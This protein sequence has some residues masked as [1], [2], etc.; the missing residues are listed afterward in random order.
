MGND[1]IP[2]GDVGRCTQAG[3]LPGQRCLRANSS[4]TPDGRPEVV[5]AAPGT[6]LPL[7]NPGAAFGGAGAAHLIDGA[8][9]AILYTYVT[10]EPQRGAAFS[11]TFEQTIAAGDLGESGL[12]DV[13][14]G[15][16][17]QNTRYVA[18][19]RGYAMTGNFKAGPVLLNIG[20]IDDPT[21]DVTEENF[22]GSAAGVGDLVP[23]PAFP[24]NELLVGQ[25]G[26]RV[27][28][29]NVQG[30]PID[31]HFFNPSLEMALQSIQD[32]DAVSSS[33]FGDSI[34]PLGDLNEDG[35]LDFA[36]GAQR[37]SNTSV[38]FVGR[39]YIFR[40]DNSPAPAPPWA[41]SRPL[42]PPWA[43]AR[44]LTLQPRPR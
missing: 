12:P 34:E 42:A 43:P 17:G 11:S 3:I 40:S 23:G 41:P 6:D 37:Y 13:F 9:R 24:A 36:V 20:R 8:T 44:G 39:G 33:S 22:S 10:P 15:A 29:V 26:P 27:G 31:V 5:V 18:T 14:L 21:P 28:P 19:G 30:R 25:S 32:P 2:I 7:D 38:L 1:V 4:T 35:F 16:P